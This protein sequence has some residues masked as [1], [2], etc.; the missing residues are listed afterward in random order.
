[1]AKRTSQAAWFGLFSPEPPAN[2]TAA[3]R[4]VQATLTELAARN[5]R[6]SKGNAALR[7]QRRTIQRQLAALKAQLAALKLEARERHRA[8]FV[9]QACS[10]ARPCL[11]N[12]AKDPTEKEDLALAEP[13]RVDALRARLHQRFEEFHLG[14]K[15]FGIGRETPTQTVSRWRK[16]YCGAA[17]AHHGMMAPWK[18]A[19]DDIHPSS[20]GRGTQARAPMPA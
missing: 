20:F 15:P 18:S 14:P 10:L 7:E 3:Q 16:G 6:A 5:V 2:I 13:E 12:I 8:D 1:M 17:L 11:F 9:A 19:R 4:S